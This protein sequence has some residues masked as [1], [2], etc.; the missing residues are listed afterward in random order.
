MIKRTTLVIIVLIALAAT[1]AMAEPVAD[2]W[3][4]TPRVGY[5]WMTSNDDGDSFTGMA[6]SASIER[7]VYGQNY[8][9][10]LSAGYA[11]ATDEVATEDGNI[12]ID[13]TTIPI[14][15]TF[16]YMFGNR[17]WTG[18]LGF[19][20]GVHISS[21]EAPDVT[22]ETDTVTGFAMAYPL[23]LMFWISENLNIGVSYQFNWLLSSYLSDDASQSA[24]LGVGFQ[25]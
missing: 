6:A 8:A 9:L 2:K 11:W 12:N 20:M 15:A 16:K 14:L 13:H 10:G 25:F 18:H 19:G 1:T 4:L 17:R 3:I 22:Q 7:N 23:G 21:T 5:A 24:N